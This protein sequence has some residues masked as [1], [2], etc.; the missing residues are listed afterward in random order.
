MAIAELFST[1]GLAFPAMSAL[2][3]AFHSE[4]ISRL[5][6][7]AESSSARKPPTCRLWETRCGP[8]SSGHRPSS[9]SQPRSIPPA[10]AD[11]H[12]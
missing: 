8:R 7:S 2:A 9:R 1:H 11:S 3:A 5:Q 12:C 6:S 4:V 10:A